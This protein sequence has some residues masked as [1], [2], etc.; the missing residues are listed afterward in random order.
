MVLF[1]LFTEGIVFV[2]FVIIF[3][4]VVVA[5]FGVVVFVGVDPFINLFFL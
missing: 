1:S 5:L 4:V 3:V 2:I